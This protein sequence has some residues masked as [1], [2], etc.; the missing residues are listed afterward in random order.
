VWEEA[1]D[2]DENKI[3]ISRTTSQDRRWIS[4]REG[5]DENSGPR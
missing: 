1:S 2:A 4:C 3:L 5:V